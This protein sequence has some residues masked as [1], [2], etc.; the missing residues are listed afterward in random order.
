MAAETPHT[1][2]AYADIPYG[3]VMTRLAAADPDRV[4]LVCDGPD[5]SVVLTRAE[6]DS[7]ANRAARAYA[8]LG[9]AHGDIA[10]IALPNSAELFI[11][12]L[13]VW[14]LGAVP[15]PVSHRLPPAE[16]AALIERADP[17][18][19]IGV[20]ED[21]GGCAGRRPVPAHLP[22][23]AFSAEPLPERVS[24]HERAMGSGG[25]TGLPKLIVAANP[26]TYNTGTASPLFRGREAVLIPGPMYHG[27][28]FSAAFGGLFSGCK[29]VVMHRFDALRC[30]ELIAQHRVDRMTVVPTMMLRIWRL[31]EEQRNS[32]D[33]SSLE[34]VMTGSAPCP[35][36]LM[37]A[38]IEWLGPEVMH[39]AFGPSERTGGTFITGTEWLA[40]PG[41]VGRASPGCEL[42]ILDEN[43]RELPPGEMGEIYLLPTGGPGSTYHYVGAEA[44]QT[45]DGW[46]S[47]G[48]M[49]YLDAEGYLYLGDRR[50]DMVLCGGR[51][52]YPAEVE[53]AIDACP[54]V[55]SSAV[56][57]LPDDDLGQ[58]LH[59]I[60]D[61]G[62]DADGIDAESIRAHL[63][64]RLVHYKIPATIEMVT[65]LL[66]DDA[67]K[68]RRS[69]LRAGRL[70]C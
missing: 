33:V 12:C 55:R 56:V 37:R 46:E 24:P 25:S 13:A 42:K 64:E 50:C 7:R 27:A 21:E 62:P 26:A 66:R 10:T 29:V 61:V 22:L 17:V 47:V 19:V 65:T 52:I 69:A 14:K 15:N 11:A 58:R 51:N 5:G 67:G 59:A 63:A 44:R 34:F 53:A 40:H 31:P 68:M 23:D 57:G 36:W 3:A 39:E 8:E 45:A 2:P 1:N 54:G 70:P 9:L 6:L 28:P 18:L 35:A 30:L 20:P 43:G 4:A 32:V 16:R 48:D 41:S 49:G 38:W 60:V